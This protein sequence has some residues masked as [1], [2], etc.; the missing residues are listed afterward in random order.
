M[1]DAEGAGWVSEPARKEM[2]RSEP[3]SA[4]VVG[5]RANQ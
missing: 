3:G 2:R 4:W 5:G 1:A